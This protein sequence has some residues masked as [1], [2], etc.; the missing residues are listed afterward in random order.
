MERVESPYPVDG[1]LPWFMA[2]SAELAQSLGGEGV[3]VATRRQLRD[4]LRVAFE[5]KGKFQL[6]EVM[7]ARGQMSRTMAQYVE[8]IRRK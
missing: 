8:G 6:I 7:I 5:R 4:A 2:S 1:V 3:R